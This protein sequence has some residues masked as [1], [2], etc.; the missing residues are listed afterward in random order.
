MVQSDPIEN[1][2]SK[3]TMLL[4]YLTP[5]SN[6]KISYHDSDMALHIDSNAAYLVLPKEEVELQDIFIQVSIIREK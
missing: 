5:Y 2:H 1:R 6:T 4:D 3:I